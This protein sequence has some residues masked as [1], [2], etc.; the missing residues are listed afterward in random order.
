MNFYYDDLTGLIALVVL[1]IAYVIKGDRWALPAY[2][3]VP[4]PWRVGIAS[5]IVLVTTAIVLLVRYG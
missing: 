2:Q 1:A 3:I 4:F 5:G